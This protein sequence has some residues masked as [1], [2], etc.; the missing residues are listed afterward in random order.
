MQ[1]RGRGCPFGGYKPG[2]SLIL[3]EVLALLALLAKC[4]GGVYFPFQVANY[5]RSHVQDSLASDINDIVDIKTEGGVF[6]FS[7]SA[8]LPAPA[9][10]DF[11]ATSLLPAVPALLALLAKWGGWGVFS[12]SPS[13]RMPRPA[14]IRFQSPFAT[15]S[16]A[17]VASIASKMGGGGY[18]FLPVTGKGASPE[19]PL[20]VRLCALLVG[21]AVAP[22]TGLGIGVRFQGQF[23]P[24]LV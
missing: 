1:N 23:C 24:T 11:K 16:S 6:S 2:T 21:D 19:A 8:R 18:F 15:A 10:P 22:V 12:F 5:E 4:G 13:A 20:H 7:P 14:H 17:S 3:P 9:H